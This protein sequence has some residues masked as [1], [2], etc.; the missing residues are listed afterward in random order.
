MH[1]GMKHSITPRVVADFNRAFRAAASELS[2]RTLTRTLEPLT[3]TLTLTLTLSL[4]LTLTLTLGERALASARAAR[5]RGH[6][7]G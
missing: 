5:G 6:A 4:S 1:P 2:P 7:A 3:L